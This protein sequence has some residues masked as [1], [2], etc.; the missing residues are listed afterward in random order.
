MSNGKKRGFQNYFL[1][2][3]NNFPIYF[4]FNDKGG[5]STCGHENHIS[6]YLDTYRGL[7]TSHMK[8]ENVYKSKY[9]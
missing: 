2:N 4:N 5:V 3:F 1:S 6:H 8:V 9:A 7:R